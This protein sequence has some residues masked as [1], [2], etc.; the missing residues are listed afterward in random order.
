MES[1]D[2]PSLKIIEKKCNFTCHYHPILMNAT[3]A[4][5]NAYSLKRWL[6]I[7]RGQFTDKEYEGE[8]VVDITYQEPIIY[9]QKPSEKNLEFLS[10]YS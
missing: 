7:R 6:L 8:D 2:C 1:L 10:M 4:V 5:E 3:C 9:S